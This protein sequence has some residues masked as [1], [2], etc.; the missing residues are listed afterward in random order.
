MITIGWVM[1]FNGAPPRRA[2]AKEVAGFGVRWPIRRSSIVLGFAA[3]GLGFGT[4]Q[5][6]K[7]GK[8]GRLIGKRC[9]QDPRTCWRWFSQPSCRS[10]SRGS[11]IRHRECSLAAAGTHPRCTVDFAASERCRSVHGTSVTYDLVRIAPTF[12]GVGKCRW[13]SGGFYAAGTW[14]RRQVRRH[15]LRSRTMP[16]SV[17]SSIT[18]PL[19]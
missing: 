8:S 4:A 3:D 1:S 12:D 5:C 16:R 2:C 13:F 9:I 11:R 19:W 18:A 17:A 7:P 10:L 6:L 14:T 15:V